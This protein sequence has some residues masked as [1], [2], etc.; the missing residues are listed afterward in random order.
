MGE[1]NPKEGAEPNLKTR[2]SQA[3]LTPDINML[4]ETGSRFVTF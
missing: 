3:S 1:I 4:L 2:I